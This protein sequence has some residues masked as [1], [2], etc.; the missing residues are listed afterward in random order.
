ML[1]HP[2]TLAEET[3]LAEELRAKGAFVVGFGGPG[4]LSFDLP[5]D[6]LTRGL[7][8]LPALQILGERRAQARGIDSAVPRHLTKVVRTA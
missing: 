1:Y 8:V 6:A 4:D 5:A 2:D 3:L 7:I